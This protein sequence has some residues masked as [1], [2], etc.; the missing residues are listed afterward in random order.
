MSRL[1]DPQ[2]HDDLLNYRLKRIFMLG[3]APAIR[4]C[5][6]KYGVTR[7]EW[8]LVAALVEDGPRSS[9]A[10]AQRIEWEPGRVSLLVTRLI[11]KGL[12]ERTTAGGE[13]RRIALRPTPAGRELYAAL[14][15]ELA[16]IN[17]RLM[18]VLSRTEAAM[19]DRCLN[20]LTAHAREVYERGAGVEVRADRHRGG[21]S[22]VWAKREQGFS[23]P[24]PDTPRAS[25][26]ASST[27]TRPG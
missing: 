27:S 13:R 2:Q 20:K 6:G 25:G 17:R 16:A 24:P 8:R 4:L 14:F 9:T 21:A 22:R 19:L 10:L 11:R 12:I 5:E 15:P 7:S 26:R 1:A 3:G 18:S 23:P